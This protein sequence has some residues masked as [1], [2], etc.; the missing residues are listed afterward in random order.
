MAITLPDETKD[1]I[2]SSIRRYFLEEREEE[3]GDLQA[4]LLLEFVLKEIGPSLYNQGIKDAQAALQSVVAEL[5]STLYEPEF[6]YTAER[7]TQSN[8][9]RRGGR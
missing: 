6:G 1:E 7:R 8:A 4:S 3:I 5:D 9:R 2:V